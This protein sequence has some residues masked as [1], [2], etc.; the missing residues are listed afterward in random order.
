VTS[1]DPRVVEVTRQ[2]APE[3]ACGLL[4]SVL[5][6]VSSG[7]A[8]ARELGCDVLGPHYTAPGLS[9]GV[10]AV[11]DSGL[12]VLVWTVNSPRR[13]LRLRAAGVDAICTDDVLGTVTVL[14]DHGARD[15]EQSR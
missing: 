13:V 2:L 9:D 3:I 10:G 5:T 6:P 12:E 1:F 8:R 15:P 4:T 14:D 11:H 7:L